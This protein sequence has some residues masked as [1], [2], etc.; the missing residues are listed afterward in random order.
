MNPTLTS[1]LVRL[2]CLF[3]TQT[4]DRAS[5]QGDW[6]SEHQQGAVGEPSRFCSYV[7]SVPPVCFLVC[8]TEVARS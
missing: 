1:L 6:R 7:G 8:W 2:R 3:R 5:S 4:P